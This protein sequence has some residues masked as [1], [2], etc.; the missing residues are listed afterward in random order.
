MKI[1][2]IHFRV[3]ETDGVSLEMD[4]WK[5]QFEKMGHEVVY[6][7]G[8][9]TSPAVIVIP[10]LSF[11]TEMH[12]NIFNNCYVKLSDYTEDELEKEILNY[13]KTVETKLQKIITEENIDLLVPN[14][15]SSLG[16]NIPIGIGIANA[17][18]NTGVKVI[19]HHH[20]FSWER[21]RYSKP[22]CNL[23][24]LLLKKYFPFKNKN[25]SHCVINNIAK[26]QMKIR[27]NL[28]SIVVPNVFDF[29]QSS[30][31]AD[32]YNQ[33]L[34]I[35]F[36]IK[37]NDL[38]ILQATRIAHRKAIEMGIDVVEKLTLMKQELIGKKLYNGEI[39]DE[40]SKIY[41]VWAG[42]NELE[43]DRYELLMK[44]ISDS[45]INVIHINKYVDHSRTIRDGEKIY[46][47]WDVYT[48]ADY[49]MYPSILEGWGNQF[50]EAIFAKVPQVVFEYPVYTT[51]I[52][53]YGFDITSLGD[54]YFVDKDGL[55]KVDEDIY[56]RVS[57]EMI[58][59]LTDKKRYEH[60]VYNNFKIAKNKL[61]YETLYSILKNVIGEIH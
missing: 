4:K 53:S 56:H 21:E 44:K 61:S 2:M 12:R 25:I 11:K 52:K 57:L 40:S 34:R 51:D 47:L 20:D 59:I 28:D 50:L 39:F 32:E 33:D 10:E 31:V 45:K 54:R 13:A 9:K 48:I 5:L 16:L 41:Y 8:H 27:R 37:S 29:N 3:G 30:W 58:D 55:F 35:K 60:I 15:V 1:A 26:E 22:T 49:V 23:V 18:L 46:S 6:I 43:E 36:G 7:A 38:V 17:I 42:L 19:N 24:S 14:N